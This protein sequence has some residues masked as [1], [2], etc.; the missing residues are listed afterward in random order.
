MLLGMRW[1]NLLAEQVDD[2]ER[3]KLPLF[4]EEAVVRRF[5]TPEFRG[6]TFY[7]VMA[8]SIINHVPGDRFGFN[9]TINPYRG[10]SHSC[11][12]CSHGDTP[13]L[14]ADGR[15]KPIADLQPGDDIYGTIFDGKYRRYVRTQVQAHWETVKPAYRITL[16]DG[17]ELIT[18]GDHRL[19]SNRGWK[20][21]TGTEWGPDRRPHLTTKNKLMGTGKFASPP[22]V[23]REYRRGYL[24]GIIRG[25]G[26]LGSY[27]Y[28]RPGRSRS[29]VHRFRLALADLEALRR[30]HQY[31]ATF[32]IET[33]EF[34]FLVASGA[35]RA[36][37][38]IRTSSLS[39]VTAIE[40]IIRWPVS[41]SLE[42][43]KGFLA[44]I[45]DAEGS[46]STGIF[47]IG[48]TDQE[49]IDW[50]TRCL[51]RLG[52]FYV[53]EER[54]GSNRPVKVIR[55]LG[56]LSEKLR[57]FH[58]VDPA[59]TRKRTFEG[60]AIK[61]SAR[62][63]VMHIEPLGI[64][65]PMYDIT[66]GTGDFIANGVVSHNCFARPTHT[67]LDFNAGKD[68]ET[69]IVVKVNAV[70]L[71]RKELRRKSWAG[72][73][74]A[75]GTN[76]DNYQRAEGHYKLMRGI[77]R[78][79]NN[80]RN[81]YS[82]LTKGT[83]IKRDIDLLQE[84]AEVTDVSAN[85]SVGTVDEKVWRQTEPGTPHPMKR[86]EVVRQLNAAGIECGVLMAPIIPGISDS[87]EQLEATV[88]AAAAAG[89]VHV[90]PIVLHLRPGVKEEF[91]PWLEANY[92][93]LITS[94]QTI[95]RRSYAPK[96]VA[97]PVLKAVGNFKNKYRVGAG[98]PRRTRKE[99]PIQPEEEQ[100][101]LDIG[102]DP[103]RHAPKWI[104]SG[105]RN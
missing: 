52:F 70:N 81:P 59:I 26:H 32:R 45:F 5:N 30:A 8:K 60:M 31:L 89:A 66:T 23:G 102:N 51:R 78:E 65:L 7:E 90:I 73:H 56:E 69:K 54:R 42:W 88:R 68:F 20:Y 16:E 47:R 9:F 55:I 80:T 10:C 14:I 38:A 15:I 93:H 35:H 77:L 86:L 92:P 91:I 11:N 22:E 71:L 101:S 29:D 19:L 84:G 34:Q 1:D 24:C 40:E 53:L 36:M 96:E 64:D 33:R 79:L 28:R 46:F 100:L 37:Q 4:G 83:L 41:P 94:Y 95:Y 72:E 13:V 87:M 3:A 63:K 6:I 39:H 25:D 97:E 99:E 12:Y 2:Q 48:N 21:V 98:H 67:Y 50:T 27:S 104:R 43:S 82:I 103:P 58:T 17:T 18:S 62:L 75:M 57:F 105:L 44:G 49:L 61:G 85:F 76:T 74:I